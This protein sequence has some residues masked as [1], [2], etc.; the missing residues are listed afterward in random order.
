MV[1]MEDRKFLKKM[2]KW[3]AKYSLNEL[4][5]VVGTLEIC[6]E[7]GLKEVE[8]FIDELVRDP[9]KYKNEIFF[10]LKAFPPKR[11]SLLEELKNKVVDE[12]LKAIN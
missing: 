8:N 5:T 12:E 10:M 2:A 3:L 7:V 6:Y 9:L 4:E 11:G 1:F